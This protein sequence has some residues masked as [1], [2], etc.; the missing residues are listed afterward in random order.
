MYYLNLS[1]YQLPIY[2]LNLLLVTIV[3]SE[4]LLST[5]DTSPMI[6]T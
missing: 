6:E 4:Y 3:L 2:Y 5:L 1:S